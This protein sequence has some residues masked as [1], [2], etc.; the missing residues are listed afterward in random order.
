MRSSLALAW[1]PLAF[2]LCIGAAA[3]DEGRPLAVPVILC[4]GPDALSCEPG[5]YCAERVIER[6]P[7]VDV[8]GEC[9]EQPEACGEISAP[10]CGCD[11]ETYAN[12]CEAAAAAVAL[13][14]AGA[15]E[16]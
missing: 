9:A 13:F 2:A 16:E 7:G 10:V 8:F 12:E 1:Q 4:A 15:C 14:A 3:C 11:G 5:T 6:C